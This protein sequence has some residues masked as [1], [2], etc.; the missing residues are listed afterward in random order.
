MSE[1]SAANAEAAD[2]LSPE[3]GLLDDQIE[4]G[5]PKSNGRRKKMLIILGVA[6]VG[7]IILG[8]SFTLLLSALQ[9][10][11]KDQVK[12]SAPVPTLVRDPQQESLIRDLQAKNRLLEEQA[13]QQSSVQAKPAEYS[14]PRD[15]NEQI[16]KLK[17]KNEK[18]EEQLRRSRQAAPSPVRSFAHGKPSNAKVAEDCTITDQTVPLGEKLKSCVEDFN[19]I[20]R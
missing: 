2:G 9:P 13:K 8:I 4:E 7:G 17:E 15:D 12:V 18:L 19:R 1:D 6:V 3:A 10:T 14:A 11:P 16:I 5:A 20:T